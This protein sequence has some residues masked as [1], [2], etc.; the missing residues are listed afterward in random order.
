[1]AVTEAFH[2]NMGMVM[3]VPLLL[4]AVTGLVFITKPGYEDAYMQLEPKLYN[5]DRELLIPKDSQWTQVKLVR[6]I[7]GYHL[8]VSKHGQWQH[9]DPITFDQRARPK[10]DEIRAL[11]ID[12][13]SNNKDRFGD[14]VAIEKNIVTTDTD[15]QI[16][17]DWNTL[18]MQQSGRDTRLINTLYK[19]HYLQWLGQSKVDKILGVL[20]LLGLIFLTTFGIGTYVKKSRSNTP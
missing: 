1:M 18:T 12:A 19:I 3:L 10:N 20:A 14:I 8:L 2:R 16:T 13:I 17:L 7:L 6:T 15:V 5:I 11:I 9:L 4:W